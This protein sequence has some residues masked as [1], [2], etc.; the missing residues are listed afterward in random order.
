MDF[1]D[2]AAVSNDSSYLSLPNVDTRYTQREFDDLLVLDC[3]KNG[4]KGVF[5]GGT[6]NGCIPNG[7]EQISEA[8]AM[9]LR[10]VV[11]SRSPF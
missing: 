10:V 5:I 6:W 3:L 8:L 9:G 11:G 1:F 2:I 4:A 7:A